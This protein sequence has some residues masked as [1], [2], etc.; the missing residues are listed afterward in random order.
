[1]TFYWVRILTHPTPCPWLVLS[2]AFLRCGL[3]KAYGIY[4]AIQFFQCYLYHFPLMI[5]PAV[6]ELKSVLCQSGILDCLT[7]TTFL[8]YP[9]DTIQDDFPIVYKI[10]STMHHVPIPN[11]HFCPTCQWIPRQEKPKIIQSV[12]LYFKSSFQFYFNKLVLF[13]FTFLLCR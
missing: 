10:Q 9:C 5:P 2:C 4:V 7:Y 1:M 8:T 12:M 11:P 3:A 6:V 13:D